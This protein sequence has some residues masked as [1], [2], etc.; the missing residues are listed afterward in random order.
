MERNNMKKLPIAFSLLLFAA[1]SNAASVTDTFITTV[2][3]ASAGSG[4]TSGDTFSWS[5]TYNNESKRFDNNYH[6]GP[7]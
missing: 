3:S 6:D 7:K 5:V 4:F 1:T 2:S